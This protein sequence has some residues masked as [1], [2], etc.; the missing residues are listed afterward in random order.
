MLD[1]GMMP[2][3][4]VLTRAMLEMVFTLVALQKKPELVQN[5]YDQHEEGTKRILKA[6]LQFKNEQLKAHAKEH[7]IEKRYIAIKKN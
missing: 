7:E 3:A 4:K 5:Y 2:Q 1:R 6:A